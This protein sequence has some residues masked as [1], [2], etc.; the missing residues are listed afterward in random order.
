M[1]LPDGINSIG[2]IADIAGAVLLYRYGLPERISRTGS[3]FLVTG[4][5]HAA[6]VSRFLNRARSHGVATFPCYTGESPESETSPI[7]ATC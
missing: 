5:V 2:L 7:R 4:Q 3:V 1:T 6:D